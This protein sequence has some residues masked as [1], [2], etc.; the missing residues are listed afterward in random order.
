MF[1][2]I[3]TALAIALA[4][5]PSGA[6]A[7]GGVLQSGVIT[8]NDYVCWV[9]NGVIADCGN[10]STG[11][12]IAGPLTSTIGDVLV[13]NNATGTSAADGGPLAAI[14]FSGSAADLVAGT[15]ASARGG[16]GTITGALK[17][18]G[19]GVTSQAACADL[20]DA[21]T[22]CTAIVGTSGHVVPNLDG[23]NIFSGFNR[24]GPSLSSGRTQ[25]ATADTLT[26][27]DCGTTIHYTAGSAVTVTVPGTLP[28][29]CWVSF[30]QQGVGQ[31]MPTPGTGATQN[32]NPHGYTKSFGLNA[33]IGILVDGNTDG[34]SAQYILWGDAS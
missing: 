4:S 26:Q 3:L 27:N 5:I 14:A 25:S 1:R 32:A 33:L 31:I 24:W 18:N 19:S 23:D 6:W 10:P 15:V 29:E 16:A 13:F 22:A 7:Q 11:R 2:S 17:A 28:V 30:E 9:Q 12:W 20:S 8:P 21:G 34:L